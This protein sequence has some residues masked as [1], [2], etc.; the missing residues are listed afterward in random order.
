MCKQQTSVSHLSSEAEVIS[1]DAGLRMDGIPTLDLRDLVI[2][3]V[4]SL[5]KPNQPIQ[6]SGVTGKPVAEHHT[7]HEKKQNS[8]KHADL[9]LRYVDHVS[10]NV[11][12]SQF[13]A[14]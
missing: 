7:P 12:P 1:L 14:M 10:S 8:T 3:V 11:R 9:D 6:R 5:T 13:G 2:E 4:S